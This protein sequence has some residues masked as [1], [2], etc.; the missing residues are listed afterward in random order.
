MR[1][2]PDISESFRRKPF[3]RADP[4]PGREPT[5][6]KSNPSLQSRLAASPK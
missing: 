5:K 4:K 3:G 2:F 1:E 6:Q